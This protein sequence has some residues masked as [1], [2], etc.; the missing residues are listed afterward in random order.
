[1]SHF[2]GRYKLTTPEVTCENFDGE[3]V[4]LDLATGHYFALSRSASVLLDGILEG[5]DVQEMGDEFANI[6]PARRDEVGKFLAEMTDRGLISADDAT[7]PQPLAPA[8]IEAARSAVDPV[9]LEPYS[10]MADLLL[11][12][13]IHDTEQTAGWPAR[14]QA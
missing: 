4:V 1:M 5:F 9:H 10:D 6:D 14:K 11:A 8:W 12:D 13:P 3:Y 2:S 7:P